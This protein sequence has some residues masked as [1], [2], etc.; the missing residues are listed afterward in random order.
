MA[1]RRPVLFVGE[2]GTAKT[3]TIHRHLSSLSQA[4]VD[5]LDINFSSRTSSMDLQRTLEHNVDPRTKDTLGPR[6]G[7]ERLVVFIDDV[8]MPAVDEYGTQQPN[9]LLKQILERGGF[10]DRGKDK[11]WKNLRDVQFVAAMAPPGGGRNAL[12]PR[13]TSR[14]SV[15]HVTFPEE[16]ALYKIYHSILADHLAAFQGETVHMAEAVTKATLQLYSFIE[17]QLSASPAKF[18]YV[19]N[20]RDLS[21]V[22]EGLCKANPDT[23]R[24]PTQFLRLWRNE[25]LRVFCDRLITKTDRVLVETKAR[26]KSARVCVFVCV[27]VSDGWVG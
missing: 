6:S 19:F 21:G 22:Y 8:N 27:C 11:T 3:V 1:G 9:A 23:T 15:L 2:T 26:W 5:V 16:A 14:F 7:K 18:H 20:L 13:L 24:T 4:S 17:Q 25:C 12:D 10:Y